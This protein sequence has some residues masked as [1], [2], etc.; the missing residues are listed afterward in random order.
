MMKI[1]LCYDGSPDAKAAVK[2][3]GHLFAG[4]TAVV[5]TVEDGWEVVARAAPD[6]AGSLL[7]LEGIIHARELAARGCADEGTGHARAAGM[8]A[9]A[10]AVPCA[11]SISETILDQ[12]GEVGA[13]LIVLGSRGLSEVKAAVVGS[14][15]RAVLEDADRP[16]LVVPTPEVALK[17]SG[18]R[19]RPEA[20][21]DLEFFS[22]RL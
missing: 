22:A 4:S 11:E 21:P 2:V 8:P 10:L 5:C 18:G 6:P 15:S 14:V 1:L 19:R 13:D 12:A 20:L 17:R 16:V 9:S 3:V 7:D